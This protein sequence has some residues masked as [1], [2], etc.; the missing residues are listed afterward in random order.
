MT[1]SIEERYEQTL[2]RIS[3]A[4][5]DGA[6]RPEDW[7]EMAAHDPE[8]SEGLDALAAL[9]APR[10]ADA[11]E[12]AAG[13]EPE[14]AR[15]AEPEATADSVRVYLREMGRVP[16]LTKE[17]EVTLARRIE[18]GTNIMRKAVFRTALALDEVMRI[19][20]Q[21]R[22][23][24][25]SVREFIVIDEEQITA[26]VLEQKRR[27]ALQAIAAV[28]AARQRFET[29][30]KR[31]RGADASRRARVRARWRLGRLRVQVIAAMRR[32]ELTEAVQLRLADRLEQTV[33]RVREAGAR[34]A[35]AERVVAQTRADRRAEPQ[36]RLRA[37]RAAVRAI[38]HAAGAGA[39]E[40]EMSLARLEKGRALAEQAKRDLAEANL[41]LVV[42]IAKK[43]VNRG[44]PLLDLV[45]EG[46][47]G[48]MRAVEK[49][50]YRRG[51]KFSTYATWW[52]R[53]AV[54]RAIQ[55]QARTIRVP[56]HMI[57]TIN[58]VTR[59]S[60]A[61]VQ[62]LGREPA[63]EEIA[64]HADVP[65]EK[66]RR[67]FEAAPIPVSLDTPIGEG[68]ETRLGDLIEDRGVVRPDSAAM[69]NVLRKETEELLR[70]LT[71]REAQVLRM[72]F[73]MDADREHSL[74]E[75][76]Q[77]FAL[78]RERIRQ[79]EAKAL[80]KL[81]HPSRSR[82]MRVFLLGTAV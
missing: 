12:A 41:R 54:G 77:H 74:E 22:E 68:E 8:A 55:D 26:D 78:T 14:E 7:D 29:Q 35:A 21:L 3:A 79:I 10:A 49:F 28:T 31:L 50:D 52:I 44:L 45:Q 5:G 39:R 61:L 66:V 2:D 63:M 20:E 15:A 62:E 76:G 65:L 37:E 11:R 71:P 81:R 57:E 75:V 51:Y 6:L 60:R 59:S 33:A 18:R 32:L 38:E 30:R 73:G 56:V 16:L 58:K 72:R 19:G 80:R 23:R 27:K 67:A 4:G 69:G 9:L 42:S 24:R 43:Y 53:Q 40:L 64:A 82:K 47:L 1:L 48:L 46:N 70:T 36:A 25:E 34:V 13:A 17:G